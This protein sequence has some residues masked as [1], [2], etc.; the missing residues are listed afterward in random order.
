MPQKK[1]QSLSGLRVG[2]LV[3]ASIISLILVIFAVSGDIK[4]FGRRTIVKTYMSSVDGLRK[5]AEVRLSGKEIGSVSEINFSGD[6]PSSAGATNNLEIVMEISGTLD[7]KPAIE[8]IRSDS[9]AVLKGAG[10][11][12]DNV[13]DITP[14]TVNG[15]PI[16]NGGVIKSLA[17]K[18][19]GDIINASQTAISNLN[20][21]SA[22][23][24]DMTG[25]IKAGEG[26]IGKFV[27]D[28]A[29]YVNLNRTIMQTEKLLADIRSGEGTAGRIV[30]DPTLY[31]QLN[32]TITQ[33]RRVVD[34]V[35]EQIL[36][37]RGTIGRLLKD[38]E[39]YNRANSLVGK[40]DETSA[41]IER[42]MAKV[43]RGE[44][45][46]GKL[47]NDEKLFQD[48]RSSAESLKNLT[49]RLDRGEGTA[50]LLLKD[51]RLYQNLNNVS[52]EITRMLYDFRQ[53]PKKYLSI[54]VTIF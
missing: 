47:L 46:L 45:N 27:S 52:A 50:G 16:Q 4:L 36:S 14:G 48:I 9:L 19:V 28:D 13:I 3:L 10:V 22:D 15:T 39:L 49:T 18:S 34:Q 44:G 2:L 25:K 40:L 43:E 5:G 1:T 29:F 38:E 37:G 53:N 54:K 24:K 51:E 41:R 26:T 20:D 30:S 23:V 17:Q 33:L 32:E 6:I 42:T 35:N 8:R 7:G 12:G 31:N 21:I 11:L